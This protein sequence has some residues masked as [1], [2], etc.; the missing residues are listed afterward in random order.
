MKN[1][2]R[3]SIIA[4][5]GRFYQYVSPAWSFLDEFTKNRNYTDARV[6]CLLAPPRSGSTLTYQVL[7][8]GIK[9]SHLTNIWNLL[10]AT[11]TIGGLISKRLTKQYTSSF[12]SNQG[13]V[14]GI[15]GEAEGLKF[16]S[17]WT[18]NTLEQETSTWNQSK[19]SA[20]KKSIELVL[21]EDDAFITGYLGHVFC[22][23]ELRELF[24][25]IIFIHL[26]RN[27][28]DNA[29]S[30]LKASPKDWI[31]T[32]PSAINISS[33]D[34]YTQIA[35]QL[36]K[37]HC[38]IYNKVEKANTINIKFEDLK[39]NPISTIHT[40]VDFSEKIGMNINYSDKKTLLSNKSFNHTTIDRD[41]NDNMALRLALEN[42]IN[43]IEDNSLKEKMNKLLYD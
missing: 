13:F 38:E 29:S 17:F 34:R 24:P 28:I 9:N 23:N 5:M 27:L 18:G 36:I 6:I 4:K 33:L 32:L 8:T 30:I 20:L 21:D 40:I 11:P 43:K 25:N 31:S 3:G 22:I 2:G 37:I 10:Y 7:T 14:E 35:K 39:K 42:E 19:A 12:N 16:W 41:S 26:T 1:S 15:R